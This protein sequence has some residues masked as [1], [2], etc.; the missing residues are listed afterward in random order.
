MT[1]AHLM[2]SASPLIFRMYFAGMIDLTKP[3]P[4]TLYGCA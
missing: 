2:R 4:K 3:K 1:R